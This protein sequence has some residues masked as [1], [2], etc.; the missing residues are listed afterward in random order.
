MAPCELEDAV[1]AKAAV[2]DTLLP[3]DAKVREGTAPVTA[4]VVVAVAA[5]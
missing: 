2:T 1:T 5:V 4:K 3:I